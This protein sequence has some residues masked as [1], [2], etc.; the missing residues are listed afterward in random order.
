MTSGIFNVETDTMFPLRER[1]RSENLTVFVAQADLEG[2]VG[3]PLEIIKSTMHNLFNFDVVMS[4]QIEKTGNFR[5]RLRE[6]IENSILTIV[7]IDRLTPSLTFE[8]G[9]ATSIGKPMIVMQSQIIYVDIA[10]LY[11]EKE[12]GDQ[13]PSKLP[14]QRQNFSAFLPGLTDD[15]IFVYNANDV[16]GLVKGLVHEVAE[17]REA[18]ASEI[19]TKGRD[20]PLN[21]YLQFLNYLEG[22]ERRR[23]LAEALKKFPGDKNLFIMAGKIKLKENDLAGAAKDFDKAVRLNPNDPDAY[24][25]KGEAYYELGQFP[26]AADDFDRA[27]QLQPFNPNAYYNK[28]NALFYMD[29][30]EG[31]AYN[32]TMAVEQKPDFANALNNQASILINRNN[33]ARA[34]ELLMQAIDKK[35]NY[36]FSFFNVA[37]A[38]KGMA[39][40]GGVVLRNLERAARCAKTNLAKGEDTKRNTYCLFL[41]YAT[42]GDRELALEYLRKC[43]NFDLP[44]KSWGLASKITNETFKNDA[45]FQSLIATSR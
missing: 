27:I 17:N 9:L 23:V 44:L 4:N 21:L 15:K 25:S 24:M 26:I 35:P 1:F 32:Y 18:I 3:N 43:A 12:P 38:Y 6:A 2:Q 29:E 40:P 10:S 28:G 11:S 45:D 33:Y 39:K 7:L 36:A 13:A 19:L 14:G 22:D 8:Y 30:E 16:E 37:R 34:I 41:V 42:L 31:A 20:I 5:E